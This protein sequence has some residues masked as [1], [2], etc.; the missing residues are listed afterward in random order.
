MFAI[1]TIL[2]KLYGC[3]LLIDKR[4][5][6]FFPKIAVTVLLFFIGLIVVS[7]FHDEAEVGILILGYYFAVFG[8]LSLLEPLTKIVCG[9]KS[10]QNYAFN[11]LSYG[12]VEKEE[13]EEEKTTIKEIKN[14][15]PAVKKRK[16]VKKETLPKKKTTTTKKKTNTKKATKK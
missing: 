10:L 6:S 1:F 9:N 11:V 7:L 3:K 4:D 13:K 12:N 5:L 14:S 8:L 15:K 2:N 16:T